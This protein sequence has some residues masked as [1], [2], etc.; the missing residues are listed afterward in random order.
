MQKSVLR[1]ALVAV[2]AILAMLYMASLMDKAPSYR[3]TSTGVAYT[4]QDSL[5]GGVDTPESTIGAVEQQQSQ[6]TQII[7]EPDPQ[8]KL[9]MAKEMSRFH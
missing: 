5:S 9:E 4:S 1:V 2:I 6:L 3:L 7:A 8:Q